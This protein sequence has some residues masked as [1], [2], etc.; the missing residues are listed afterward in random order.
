M[1]GCRCLMKH[2][3]IERYLY[4]YIWYVRK[5]RKMTKWKYIF[6]YLLRTEPRNYK[7]KMKSNSTSSIQV[8]TPTNAA[9]SLSVFGQAIIKMFRVIETK[10]KS[11]QSNKRTARVVPFL[12]SPTPSLR[13]IRS[14]EAKDRRSL[15]HLQITPSR[16]NTD[17]FVFRCPLNCGKNVNIMS[18]W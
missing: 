7:N 18:W 9:P 4:T 12:I 16:R 8:P 13:Y 5:L 11:S 2:Y 6:N 17:T 10:A 3:V 15:N 14:Q 1:C